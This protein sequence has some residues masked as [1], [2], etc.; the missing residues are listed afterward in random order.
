[1]K[2]ARILLALFFIFGLV[3]AFVSGDALYSRFVYVSGLIVLISFVWTRWV[4]RG[5]ELKRET[6]TLRANVG[7]VFQE[8]YEVTNTS[9]LP[10]V[11]IE[12]INR[13]TLPFSAGSRLFTFVARNQKRTYIARTWLI[14]RGGFQLGPA[15][16]STGDPFG[17]FKAGKTISHT[18][19]LVVYPVIHEIQ[20][21]P[22]P[23]GLLPG[24]QIINRKSPD[25]TPH[26]SGVREYV[27][28]DALKRI[29]WLTSVRRN[30]LM[31]KE[32]EQDPQAE[33]WLFLDSHRMVHSEK[34]YKQEGFSVD[35]MIFARRP[36]Y[37]MPPST[38]EY[39]VSITAS[40]AHY[41][42][43]Q[44]RA[45]GYASAGYSFD[46]H[47]AERSERQEAKILETLSFVE[48][49]GSLS[50]AE[51]VSAQASQLPKGSTVLLVTPTVRSNLLQAVD[52]L[53]L[54]HLR[55]IVILLNAST[56]NGPRGTEDLVNALRERRVPVSVISCGDDLAQALSE[57]PSIFKLQEMSSWRS[58]VL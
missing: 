43:A 16:I 25:V 46:F 41:F 2:S 50:I 49:N 6:R 10:A 51:L 31:V 4:A 52:D 24:G 36:A 57:I 35:A 9:F 19:T 1:M 58:P 32:F 26:A 13:S 33:V 3:G 23:M 22:L 37:K 30:R 7:E 38:L 39:A 48:A 8:Q 45:V 28:G 29:H 47:P 17:I 42:I 21:F 5:L 56:F 53:I 15:R 40:L 20:S 44:R 18:E 54:R 12:I 14:Q 27:H 34:P 55:P 11:W